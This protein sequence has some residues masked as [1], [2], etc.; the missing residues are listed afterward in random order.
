LKKFLVPI[1]LV[2]VIIFLITGCNSATTSSTTTSKA[3]TATSAANPTT[4]AKASTPVASTSTTAAPKYGGTFKIIDPYGPAN[5]LGWFA[6]PAA[7]ATGMYMSPMFECLL[8]FDEKGQIVGQLA[9][10]YK[11]ADDMKSITL[12]IRKGVLY[13]DGSQ[14]TGKTI[15]W[16]FDKL[17]E[18]KV[19]AV[20]VITSV[21]LLDDYT[22][23]LNLSSFTNTI[24]SDL[25]TL[26]IPSQYTFEQ[27]GADYQRWN[28]VGT[29]PFKFDSYKDG[30][31]IKYTKFDK[32]WQP[33][34]PYLN[35][36]EM[37]FVGDTVTAQ[38]A[39]QTGQVDAVGGILGQMHADLVKQGGYDVLTINDA[40]ATLV[41]D[42]KNADSP[43]NNIKVRMALDYAIDRNAIVKAR[44][45]GWW[46]PTYQYALPGTSVY[47]KDLGER[48]YDPAKAKQLLADAGYP[49]G[50]STTMYT[51][52]DTETMA[53]LQGYLK[54]VGINATI[55]TTNVAS[56]T[57]LSTKGWKNGM[58]V[59][60]A[61]FGSN[62]NKNYKT[63]FLTNS[64]LWTSVQKTADMDALY[65]AAAASKEFDPTLS[66]K[67]VQYVFDNA[68]V[69]P[70][71]C[72]TRGDIMQKYVHG[73]GLY[74]HGSFILWTPGDIWLSK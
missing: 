13:H 11:V 18:A 7:S 72:T 40:A 29:G 41:V 57:S 60:P 45:F 37:D 34:K 52:T 10:S 51:G 66:K 38:T 54:A 24:L 26:W 47:I 35:A 43:Y 14:M 21:D 27:K 12:N 8:T 5:T 56:Q 2:L 71:W 6:D 36:L 70:L 15:K 59:T 28:P 19:A 25:S 58:L 32:Y 64:A 44:G 33:G 50:F 48:A 62:I 63:Y 69:N 1:C 68:M 53:S 74:S 39:F 46:V 61:A 4:T 31:Y 17:A 49:N 3:T 30:A 42:S 73:T 22:V 23:R 9:E 55:E 65:N 16:H 20:S 67:M